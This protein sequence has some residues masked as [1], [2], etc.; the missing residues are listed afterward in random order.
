MSAPT[1]VL[2][3]WLISPYCGKVRKA[4]HAK[5]LAFEVREYPGLQAL[6]ARRLSKA[7]KLPVLDYTGPSGELERIQDSARILRFLEERHPEPSLW[8]SDPRERGLAHLLE[9]WADE[10]LFWLE[11]YFRLADPVASKKAGA[12]LGAGRPA[13]EGFILRKAGEMTYRQRFKAVGLLNFSEAELEG[14]VCEHLDAIAGMLADDRQWLVGDRQSIADIALAAQLGEFAR[15]S[16]LADAI[17]ARP[18]L[19]DWLAR[20]P[21]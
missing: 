16:R 9:D 19:A 18:Q 14:M 5:G 15:T 21:G 7:R 3:Q 2:H 10:A 12:L 17:E 4:L 1:I 20:N 11:A 13:W 8:P 6:A